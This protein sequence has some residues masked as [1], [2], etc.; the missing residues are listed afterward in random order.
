[1]IFSVLKNRLKREGAQIYPLFGFSFISSK[2][3]AFSC[4]FPDFEQNSLTHVFGKLGNAKSIESDATVTLIFKA[5]LAIFGDLKHKFHVT[6]KI[7][8][9]QYENC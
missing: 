9:L 8:I 6:L 4:Y 1:M 3:Q 2:R 5:S 7:F